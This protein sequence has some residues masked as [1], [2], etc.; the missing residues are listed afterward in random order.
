MTRVH[1]TGIG[2]PI[3]GLPLYPNINARFVPCKSEMAQI[4]SPAL[5]RVRAASVAA[6]LAAIGGMPDTG[7]P[8]LPP[9]LIAMPKPYPS[10]QIM[11]SICVALIAAIFMWD[12]Y[13]PLGVGDGVL[14]GIP[15]V[16]TLWLP[17]WRSTLLAAVC[18]TPLIMLG[19]YL[20]PSGDIPIWIAIINRIMALVVIWGIALLVIRR[21]EMEVAL[22]LSESSL[23]E[24]Q[25]IA[26]LGYWHRSIA[27]GE[28]YWSE[29]VYRIFGVDQKTFRASYQSFLDCLHPDDRACVQE[30]VSA[31][32]AQRTPYALVY[33]II[34]PDGNE[35]VLFARGA[36]SYDAYGN[37][38]RILGTIQDIT[39]RRRMEQA[40]Q[41][42][43]DELERRVEQRTAELLQANRLLQEEIDRRIQSEAA[44]ITSEQR[45]RT[46][47]SGAPV[48][49]FVLDA[50]GVF[51]L[52]EGRELA[53]LGLQPGEVVG[54]SI[55]TLYAD[56]PQVL[57]NVRRALAGEN[58]A[59]ITLLRDNWLDSRFSPLYDAQGAVAGAIGVATNVTELRQAEQSRLV[60][61]REQRDTLIREVHHRIKNNLQGVIGLLRQHSLVHPELHHILDRAIA[62]VHS[63][64]AVHGLYSERANADIMLCDM[65]RAI[66]QS[67]NE[68]S[69][70][71]AP[72]SLDLSVDKPIQVAKEEAVPIALI[73][74]ELMLN[75]LK[76]GS[77][78]GVA[79]PVSIRLQ[80][81]CESVRV[82]V[83][84]GGVLPPYFSLAQRRGIGTGLN[85]VLALL[86]R[87]GADLAITDD[88]AGVTTQITLTPP[89]ICSVIFDDAT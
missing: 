63:V 13:T 49:V 77:R 89:V 69:P 80:G 62:Q 6:R 61:A 78:E 70:G 28:V 54:Q 59:S 37:P 24:A 5:S 52:I 10:H 11:L 53:S 82:S 7:M 15:V 86:P 65:L 3:Q 71:L 25:R 19:G 81:N 47:V 64:A 1:A 84:N 58:V 17:V 73:M 34:R 75:A 48:I 60:E 27:H 35:R 12:V 26:Q 45:L 51:Q 23:V 22:Q 74:N 46:V 79:H 20:S 83:R 8:P 66:S 2:L 72:L 44:L 36:V 87:R 67:L 68:V 18:A 30:T 39:E 88:A 33:R 42:A 32:I 9:S 57:A 43:H 14:Y 16:L 50:Q 31:A 21:K 29:E 41:T 56:T 55:F 85:L 40:L 4:I 38:L 76:H